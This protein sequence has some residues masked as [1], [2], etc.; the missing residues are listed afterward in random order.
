MT[1]LDDEELQ[2]YN[3][4][5]DKFLHEINITSEKYHDALRFSERGKTIIL[6]RTLN[7]RK[8]NNYNPDFLLAWQ[9]NMDIQFSLDNY[10]IVTYITDC[11]TKGDAALTKELRQALL[12]CKGCNDWETLNHLKMVYFKHKQVSVAEATYRLLNGLCLK[13]SNIT[14][15][16]IGT[17]F[18]KNRSSFFTP[19]NPVAKKSDEDPDDADF[20]EEEIATTDENNNETVGLPGRN[21]KY[22]EID[23]IHKRYSERPSSLSDV[24]LAQFG[25]SYRSIKSVPKDIEWNENA[26]SQEGAIRKFGKPD[27]LPKFIRLTSGGFMVLR[28][29]PI[30]LRIHSSKKKEVHEGIY[31][32]LLLFYPWRNEKTELHADDPIQCETLFNANSKTIERNKKIIYPNSPMID[33]VKEL[34]ETNDTARPSHLSDSVSL[35]DSTAQQ[36]NIEDQVELNEISPLDTSDLPIEA[37]DDKRGE[38]PDGSPYKPIVIPPRDQMFQS[39]RQLSF[40]QRIVFDKVVTYCKSVIM[41]ERSGNLSSMEDPPH[42][43]VH[44]R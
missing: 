26:S 43:I 40:S 15:T 35:I 4:D 17:G 34:L 6:K 41:A 16:Y 5:L 25:T 12:N 24:C 14:C 39:A 21:K 23:T 33:S 3:N 18:P 42:L 37:G 31:S 44:G 7:E 10:A 2:K 29:R 27:L 36:N 30:I 11:M 32:E 1:E 9:A 20:Q 19:V 38:T 8:I 13:K 22:K 28:I